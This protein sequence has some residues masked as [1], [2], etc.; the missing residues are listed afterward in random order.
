[1]KCKVINIETGMPTIEVGQKRLYLEIITARNQRIKALKVIHGYGSHG[2]GGKLKNGILQFLTVKKKDGLVKEFVPGEDW[3][4]FNQAA[5]DIL[6][7]CDDLR[8]DTDLGSSNPGIT[9]VLI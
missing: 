4:I 3:N 8:K 7:Q 6:E 5:R 2:V 9:I 1:M